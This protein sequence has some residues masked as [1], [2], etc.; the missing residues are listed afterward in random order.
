[1]R[2]AYFHPYIFTLYTDQNPSSLYSPPHAPLQTLF[3]IHLHLARKE[4]GEECVVV[5]TFSLS[6]WEAETK[7]CL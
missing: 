2:L 7:R 4:R 1:M 5:L 6:T 3:I